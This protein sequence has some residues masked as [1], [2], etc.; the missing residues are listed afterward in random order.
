MPEPCIWTIDLQLRR[1][2]QDIASE[3]VPAQ[4][5]ALV[6]ELEARSHAGGLAEPADEAP[7]AAAPVG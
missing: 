2:F 3:P 7:G 5:L 1:M 6:E 4:L